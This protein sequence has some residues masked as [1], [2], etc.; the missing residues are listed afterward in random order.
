MHLGNLSDYPY[1]SAR[2]VIVGSRCAVATSQ[3]LATLAGM[4]MF[5]AGGN[6]V[7]AA[8]AMAITLTVVEPTANSTGSDAFAL[9]W[10]G[11]LHGLN[12]SG[13]SSQGLT[14][15]HFYG[16]EKIPYYGW[17]PV[18]VPGAVSAWRALWERWGSLPF[19]QLFAPAIRY[20]EGG[21]P[22]SPVIAQ[23]WK[24]AEQI[25]LPL[26]GTEFEPF[27]QV[28]FPGGR[29]PAV[30]EIW[31]SQAHAQTLRE[32]AATGTESF[33]SGKL[34]EQIA[35][36][37]S[38]S[39]GFLSLADLAA[40]QADWVT[41]IS[42]DYRGL[43]V[44]EMPPNTQGLAALMALNI[45]EGFDLGELRE[46]RFLEETRFLKET[47]FP[48]F[49]HRESAESYHLQIEA[50]KLAFADVRRHA[51]DPSC[52]EVP[53]E[54]LLDK[55]YAASRRQLIGEKAIPQANP[56]LPKGGTVYLAAADSELMVSFIQSNYMGFGSGILIPGTGIALQNRGAGFTLQPGHP[57]QFAPAKRPFHTIIPGFLTRDGVPVGPFGVMGGPMQPQGHLQVV[58]N[59]VDYG[60][61]PQA[62]LDAPR[63]QFVADNQVVLEPAVPELV[64]RELANRG[65]DVYIGNLPAGS[66]V[67]Q[68]GQFGRGQIILR[69]N[70]VFVAASEP[71]GDG[72]ALA[73]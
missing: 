11:Q 52:M 28:F 30:G 9:V 60:M 7:D 19:E 36:F 47:R 55:R 63:W 56:G 58:V 23:T 59:M 35:N 48:Q 10:D 65:H 39:G 33:Y 51:A 22:V 29:A 73:W 54:Q 13:R 27:K 53:V 41:P 18:T 3:P 32:I 24:S 5:W 43:T 57:N 21:F 42:T 67:T 8:I 31:R 17:L 46:T 25:Y 69:Q 50:M 38:A 61:N 64:V 45:L 12:A 40:H 71:R 72:M 49:P 66:T 4:E 62:A 44:W 26:T 15:N 70:G 20:A 2:R 16:T 34:A 37:A 1:P 14:A 6:A 68:T